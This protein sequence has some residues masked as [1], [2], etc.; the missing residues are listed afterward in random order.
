MAETG[1]FGLLHYQ[2]AKQLTSMKKLLF[3]LVA[4]GLLA[5][6]HTSFAALED[7]TVSLDGAQDGGGGRQGSGSGTLTLDTTVNT[8]TFNNILWSGLSADSTASH[9]HG[10]AAPGVSTSVLYPLNPTYTQVGPGI[11]SGQFSGTLPLA[12]GTGGFT[13]AQQISQLEGGLWYINIHSDGLQNGFPGGEIRG[14]IIAVPEPST[15]A[16]LSLGVGAGLWRLRRR[17]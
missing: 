6:N 8:L 9:I 16:L 14:Q 10:P 5:L 7:F 15:L 1:N 12:D 13:I 2:G 11:R 4:G 3:P 17:N